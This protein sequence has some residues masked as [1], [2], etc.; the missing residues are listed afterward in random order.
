MCTGL[1]VAAIGASVLSAGGAVYSGQQQKK[2]SN[3]QAAQ[4]EADAEAAQ[5][6]A[7]VEADR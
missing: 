6:A 4:A 5:A 2:M 3:Y 7:R 1:E